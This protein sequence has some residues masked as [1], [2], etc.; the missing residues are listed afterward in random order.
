MPDGMETDKLL[1]IQQAEIERLLKENA[2]LRAK[3]ERAEI[4][5]LKKIR[6]HIEKEGEWLTT[7]DDIAR[8]L[9]YGDIGDGGHYSNRQEAHNEP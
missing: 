3:L 2:G 8:D 4:E 7:I 5:L 1:T 6:A 9:G